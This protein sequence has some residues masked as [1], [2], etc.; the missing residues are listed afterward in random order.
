MQYPVVFIPTG[1]VGTHV[2]R[3]GIEV[4]ND[5][6]NLHA[7]MLKQE[8]MKIRQHEKKTF[9][10]TIVAGSRL[11]YDVQPVEDDSAL[12][13]IWRNKGVYEII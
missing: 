10:R 5:Q 3:R 2:L 11:I 4:E 12:C 1:G 9:Y 6:N 8:N 13:W 7:C